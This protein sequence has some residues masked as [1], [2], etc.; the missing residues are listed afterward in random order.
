M[1]MNTLFC[2]II[3][4]FTSSLAR[5]QV[6]NPTLD[7]FNFIEIGGLSPYTDYKT[8]ET[9]HFQMI[10][11][12]KY[13]SFTKLAAEDLEHVHAILSPILKWAPR[14]KTHILVTDNA[15]DA[16][17][18][19]MPAFRV[20]IVLIATPPDPY[21][22]TSYSEDW[23]KLLTFHEYTHM[24]NIDA[25]T[26]LW[27]VLRYIYGDVIRPTG[28]WPKWMLEG[29]AVYYETKTS[30]L[31][32][33]RSPYYEGI[34]RSYVN[35]GKLDTH[36]NY[37]MTLDR[38][39]G[40]FPIFPSG[41]IPYLF[42][43]HLWQ[44]VSEDHKNSDEVIGE[45]SLRSSHRFPYLI[46]GNLKNLT[47][48]GWG[49]YWKKFVA[50]TQTRMQD[51]IN[52]VKSHG[53]T[54]SEPVTHSRYSALGGA[55]SPDNQW[56]AWTDSSLDDPHATLKLQNRQSK[57]ITEVDLKTEG[58]SLSFSPDSKWLIYSAL[59]K[60]ESYSLFADLFAY[61]L[62]SGKTI[63]LTHGLRAKD[64]SFSADG[65]KII[66][67]QN[68]GAT[69][70]LSSAEVAIE[71]KD[72][73]LKNIK[74]AYLPKEFAILGSPRFL[75]NS[76]TEIV[77]SE[78][79]RGNAYSDL[80]AQNLDSHSTQTLFHDGAMNRY[81]YPSSKGIY[82]VSDKSGIEN[83][84]LLN[85]TNITAATNVVTGV[86][87]P[88]TS[89]DGELYGSLIHSIGMEIEKFNPPSKNQIAVTV[90]QSSS[91]AS[92][93]SPNSPKSIAAAVAPSKEINLKDSEI[94]PYSPWN[95]LAPRQWVLPGAIFGYD[96]Q[97]GLSLWGDVLGFDSSGRHEY[98]ADA[99][100]RFKT[101][102]TDGNL[103]Y[104]Y[105]GFRP[106]ITLGASA[107][108]DN[109]ATDPSASQYTRTY[110]T[111]LQL[112][113]PVF[114]TYSTLRLSTSGFLD[115]NRMLDLNSHDP[116][117][118]GLHEFSQPIVPGLGAQIIYTEL[119][120]SRLGFMPEHGFQALAATQAHFEDST[121]PIW[122][123]LLSLTTFHQLFDHDVL[124]PR[125]RFLGTT[126]FLGDNKS[127]ILFGSG[128]TSTDTDQLT[129]R[130]YPN[131]LYVA[132][133]VG[134]ASLDFH[135][136]IKQFFAGPGIFPAFLHQLH[137]FVFGETAVVPST[138]AAGNYYLPSAGGGLTLDTLLFL[139]I[140]INF[141]VQVARGF[142]E[143]F[144]GGWVAGFY[145]SSPTVIF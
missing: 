13:F 29:L 47:H 140:P 80:V 42:G 34:L 52:K 124:Q 112:E 96:T 46:S 74:S 53:E 11:P 106:K 123:Y 100:Y 133:Q 90:T 134:D 18:F 119:D 145:L 44:E 139:N 70:T 55:I 116:V 7:L 91:E 120:Q 86:Q 45:Y 78:Q 22:S 92:L 77:F 68:R 69:N 121:S 38:V 50:R 31:G 63:Q 1:K 24:L 113:Y 35:D 66:F 76:S 84:Y 131:V 129:I 9:E 82:F 144:G 14:T 40:D 4:L 71:G 128:I 58:V 39:N 114:F 43:Y 110:E 107:T 99:G 109:I 20:G 81:P 105:Y 49:D 32:R 3:F 83:I 117:P 111:S 36:K 57:E 132:R 21:F 126:D 73:E 135:F 141:N 61:H 23:I 138:R 64:P 75:A 122:K 115:W 27:E 12:E 136:P 26:G 2:T 102:T 88:F 97:A 137:G 103:S 33:G 125:L 30:I 98:F 19:T 142:N 41:E 6:S 8:F 130:G 59:R 67:I 5:A 79:D 10:Y 94:S 65:K 62:E 37:G 51:Q 25:T 48:K 16:N 89:P 118:T 93:A 28:L 54:P 95:S 127:S 72:F 17:G 60:F 101:K 85:G 104:M 56:M 87:L 15:D 108:T 143:D